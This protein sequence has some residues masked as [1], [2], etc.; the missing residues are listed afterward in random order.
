VTD[1]R[2]EARRYFE[3]AVS[4]DPTN[5]YPLYAQGYDRSS[6]GDWA[7]AR[8]LFHKA[9]KLRPDEMAFTHY[10]S[11][12]RMALG[13]HQALELEC[14]ERLRREPF[15]PAAAVLLC[16]VLVTAGLTNDATQSVKA[17]ERVA[18]GQGD[19]GQNIARFLRRRL[20]YELG[21]F[22]SLE[23]DA[24]SDRTP[25]GRIALFQAQL[26]QGR[27]LEAL[28]TRSALG[29][30]LEF[31]SGILELILSLSWNLGGRAQEAGECENRA[32]TALAS[33]DA[34]YQRAAELLR[35]KT[36]PTDDAIDAVALPPDSKSVLL[37]C[38]ARKH[39][40]RQ[41]ELIERARRLNVDPSFPYHLVR[42]ATAR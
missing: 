17:F 19:S 9:A 40:A 4:A 16:D 6:C 5:P 33:G 38:L 32:V 31:D 23:K 1:D 28:Q 29:R 41:T 8:D 20:Y 34:D 24:S 26:E 18:Q 2:V 36:P 21:D 42:R 22:V 30:N 13:E 11:L 35:A 39:P 12:A 7:G 10:L 37:A 15:Q 3:R 27:V 25:A 14:R